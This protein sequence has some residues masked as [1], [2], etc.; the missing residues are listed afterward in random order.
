M[1]LIDYNTNEIIREAT[2]DEAAESIAQAD[3][4]GG[5]G[6]IVVDIDGEERRCYVVE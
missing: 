3:F 2:D 1:N 4:D 5:A 6:V